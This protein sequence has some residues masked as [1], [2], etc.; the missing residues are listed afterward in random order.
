MGKIRTSS[1]GVGFYLAVTRSTLGGDAWGRDGE[2][3]LD[4]RSHST[5]RWSVIENVCICISFS[6]PVTPLEPVIG[7]SVGHRLVL[8]EV[9]DTLLV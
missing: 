6:R 5:I 7:E 8:Q 4:S 2:A 9:A 1:S 3:E